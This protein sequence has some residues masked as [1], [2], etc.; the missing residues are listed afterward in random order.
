MSEDN[1]TEDRRDHIRR[2]V[3]KDV[4]TESRNYNIIEESLFPKFFEALESTGRYSAAARAVGWSQLELSRYRKQNPDFQVLCDLA[5]EGYADVFIQEAQRR[6]VKGTKKPIVGG[7]ERDKIVAHEMQYSDRLM[8]LFLK[9]GDPTFN[10]KSKLEIE[11]R[12]S[13]REEMNLRDLS[14]RA[15]AK[16]RELLEIL[17]EDKLMEEAR[18]DRERE[19]IEAGEAPSQSRPEPRQLPSGPVTP[20]SAV[21]KASYMETEFRYPEDDPDYDGPRV[22]DDK[23]WPP[24]ERDDE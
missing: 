24:P 3:A 23:K 18:L 22:R 15:R 5:L 19:A 16:L 9:R 12:V 10:E 20:V 21:R 17:Q 13:V 1:Y 14:P 7:R 2:P 4:Y 11:G 6:A 8:E